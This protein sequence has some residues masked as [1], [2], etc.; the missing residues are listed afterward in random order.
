MTIVRSKRKSKNG[1]RKKRSYHY[2]MSTLA[3]IDKTM[4]T[5][6]IARRICHELMKGRTLT[7]IC[8]DE[9]TPSIVT[10]FK[11]L[12]PLSRYYH[13]EFL[14]MYK[15]AREVQAEV[16]AD[17]TA[18]IAD[19][20]SNDTYTQWNH[21]KKRYEEKI[22]Y[23]HIKRSELR[24]R[25]RQWLAAHLLPRKFS[26]RVQVTGKDDT[27]LV[28]TNTKLIVKFVSPGDSSIQKKENEVK[29]G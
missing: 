25:N 26:D 13:E 7:K 23:D 3:K 17:S 24:V 12:N 22:D 28:P 5:R 21:R 19:D 20:G 1:I 10:V 8:R 9:N 2:S 14:E 27:P 16:F 18:D 15:L 11:W 29:N 4:Y 6:K